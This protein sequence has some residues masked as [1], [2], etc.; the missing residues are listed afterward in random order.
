MKKKLQFKRLRRDLDTANTTIPLRME[1][2]QREHLIF[3]KDLVAV[4]RN[5]ISEDIKDPDIFMVRIKQVL[6]KVN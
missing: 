3:P 4:R 6:R 1:I 5:I 2:Y